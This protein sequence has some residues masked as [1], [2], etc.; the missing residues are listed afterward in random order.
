[1]TGFADLA[2]EKI[3][4]RHTHEGISVMLNR[5]RKENPIALL[6]N[7][8]GYHLRKKS[9]RQGGQSHSQNKKWMLAQ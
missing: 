1:V 8:L 9:M 5:S 3:I 6:F 2:C 4:N 7:L